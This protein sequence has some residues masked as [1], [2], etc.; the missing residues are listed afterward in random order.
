MKVRSSVKRIC[1]YCYVVKRRGKI[2]VYCAKNPKVARTPTPLIALQAPACPKPHRLSPIRSTSRGSSFTQA[3]Q[4]P[5]AAQVAGKEQQAHLAHRIHSLPGEAADTDATHGYRI[6]HC[7]H[8]VPVM[9]CMASIMQQAAL[10]YTIVLLTLHGS[11]TQEPTCASEHSEHWRS[12]LAEQLTAAAGA[13]PQ[14]EQQQVWS[15]RHAAQR[16]VLLALVAQAT[17]ASTLGRG[18]REQG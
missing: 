5:A 13:V 12:C 1:E 16:H 14:Q 18:R 15:G 17:G 11:G 3:A 9:S 2:R 8:Y 6:V 4:K 7:L 10:A